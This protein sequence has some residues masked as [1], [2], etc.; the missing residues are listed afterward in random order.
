MTAPPTV[1]LSPATTVTPQPASATDQA[2]AGRQVRADIQAMRAL[3]VLLVVGYH[4]WPQRLTGGYVGV[5]VF[6]V[7]SGFLI[8]THLLQHQPRTLRDLG[9][10]WGRRIRRLLP[11]ALLV[12]AASLLATWLI[13]P[14][15]L[16]H[17]TATQAV[18]SAFYVQN[19]SL[20]AE[21]VD[22]MAADNVPTAVQHYWS[23]SIEEQF[24]LG[25]PVMILIAGAFIRHRGGRVLPGV[26]CVIVVVTVASFVCSALLSSTNDAAYFLSWTR[27]WE[28]GIGGIAAL[29]VLWLP[30]AGDGGRTLRAL[31]TWVGLAG[32]LYSAFVFDDA[33]VFPGTAALLPVSATALVILAAAGP[34]F[35]SPHRLLSLRP[36]QWIG[37]ISYSVYLWH[38]PFVVLLP[39]ALGRPA[40]WPV[41]IAAVGVVVAL[42]WA[43]KVLV[44]DRLRGRR[45]LGV[46]LRRSFVFAL[47]G[48][49]VIAALGGGL[50]WRT[51]EASRGPSAAVGDPC[52]GAQV[53]VDPDCGAVHGDELFTT[54]AF[55]AKDA[56]PAGEDGC[57]VS[58]S[59]VDREVCT[60]GVRSGQVLDIALVGNSHAD[61]WLPAL[62]DLAEKNGWR[63]STYLI[64]NCYTV[65]RRVDFEDKRTRNCFE[66]NRWAISEARNGDYDLIITGNRSLQPLL[67]VPEPKMERAV[68]D[69]YERVLR[70]WSE[71]GRPV[72][73]VQDAPR[74][75]Y[76]GD[77][78]DPECAALH[79]DD[80]AAC[81]APLT[82]RAVAVEQAD[83]ARRL[84]DERVQVFDPTPYVCPQDVCRVVVGG[85]IVHY[86]LHH[87]SGTFVRSLA[88]QLEDAI[89]RVV[90]G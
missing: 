15:T 82:E 36:V 85:V 89:A 66:W 38:W 22:Y 25:W 8:T 35:G 87:L 47:A 56:S 65:D 71:A 7:I 81:D 3:A 31:L 51:Q 12:L 48:A 18:A 52:F 84:D 42:A 39:Y 21:A 76:E 19:W 62:A 74:S 77:P 86:D 17:D 33:T 27:F 63:I 16:W 13:A 2:A 54:P 20:A 59:Y 44:E 41:K 26:A 69:A 70:S 67:G 28:L 40:A 32:I 57:M 11:A 73:V 14:A 46:P 83:A 24:Y 34:G 49:V 90:E 68:T 80:L 55:A 64:E 79:E 6:F 45:P 53:L 61:M 78:T 23:L 50:E 75:G 43:T 9:V 10:F 1:S 88:P 4:F 72:L 29:V 60:Y 30:G 58:G 37:D 5:D